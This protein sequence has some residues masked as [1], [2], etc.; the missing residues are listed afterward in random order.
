MTFY[1]SDFKNP[2]DFLRI[3]S[4][5]FRAPTNYLPLIGIDYELRSIWRKFRVCEGVIFNILRPRKM[6]TVFA[7]DIFKGISMNWNVAILSDN[8]LA[9]K[10]RQLII[11]ANIGLVYWRIHTPPGLKGFTFH[12]MRIIHYTVFMFRPRT[13]ILCLICFP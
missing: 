9:P 5:Y 6:T 12:S 7:G 13:I 8:G 1:S 11:W 10:R 2:Y 3:V 4:I